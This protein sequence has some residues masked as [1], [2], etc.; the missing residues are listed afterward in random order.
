V[1]FAD[2]FVIAPSAG[3]KIREVFLGRPSTRSLD[4]DE[5]HRAF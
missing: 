5:S 4:L 3:L 2:T 1:F